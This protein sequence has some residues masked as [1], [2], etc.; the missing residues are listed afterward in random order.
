MFCYK[1]KNKCLPSIFDEFDTSV[2][3]IHDHY[4]RG[5]HLFYIQTPR[6]VYAENSVRYKAPFTWNSLSYELQNEQ[7]QTSF[8]R[9]L[10]S[11]LLS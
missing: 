7:C 1:L 5:S 11:Y 10:I 8:K 4:T 2:S 9:K 3:D 6:T